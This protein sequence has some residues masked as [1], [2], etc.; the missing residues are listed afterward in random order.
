MAVAMMVSAGVAFAQTTNSHLGVTLTPTAR[1]SPATPDGLLALVIMHT[2]TSSSGVQTSSLPLSIT[3]GN[4]LEASHLSDCRVRNVLD[5][6]APISAATTLSN[7]TNTLSFSTVTVTTDST[8]TLA[9][10]CDIAA[11]APLGGTA[12]L[13]IIPGDIPETIAGSSTVVT[14]VVGQH[15]TGGTGT[16]SGTVTIASTP[17]TP[18]PP[19]IPGVPNTGSGMMNLLLLMISG[20]VIA[21]GAALLMRRSV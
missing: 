18:T 5:L 8:V 13:S 9:V 3:F 20:A 1:L 21:G 11:N 15:P 10:T 16:T 7:G 2:A 14:P 19:F 4:G 12:L 17:S 6:D